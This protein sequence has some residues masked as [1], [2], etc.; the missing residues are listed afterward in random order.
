MYIDKYFEF[1]VYSIDNLNIKSD[2]TNNE[3]TSKYS[4]KSYYE[5]LN[6]INSVEWI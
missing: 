5:L 2:K 4:D 3:V 6:V 1:I